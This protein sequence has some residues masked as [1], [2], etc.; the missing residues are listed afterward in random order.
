M[1]TENRNRGD[2][3]SN[4]S[5]SLFMIYFETKTLA[6]AILTPKLWK[7]YVVMIFSSYDPTDNN[8]IQTSSL[9]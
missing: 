5:S 1:R 9:T 4:Y 3:S 7:R 6:K 2:A 8:N